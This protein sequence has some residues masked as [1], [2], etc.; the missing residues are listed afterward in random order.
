MNRRILMAAVSAALM[1]CSGDTGFAPPDPDLFVVQAYL[2]AGQP[3]T[4]VTITG[5]LP[6][7]AE[8]GEIA[9]PISDALVTLIKGDDRHE[10]TAT[11]GSP[12]AYHDPSGSVV[13]TP[14][15]AFELE[16]VVEGR[17]ARASTIVPQPPGGLV[18]S[19]DSLVAI[20][21]GVGGR[22]AFQLNLLRLDWDNP[23][24]VLHFVAVEGLDPLAALLPT[25]VEGGLAGGRFVTEPTPADSA[26]VS[27]LS[28]T[29]FGPHRVSLYRV[30]QEYAD[31]Y[32]G[33]VQD[34]RDL[35]EPPSNVDGALGIFTAFASDSAFFVVR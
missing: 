29:Y 5:V 7:D 11:S 18:L 3:V 25:A 24:S 10:L 14:G 27:Q 34:S 26:F 35:N 32:E 20:E 33:L 2:F 23:A 28:L 21:P 15:D 31:L 9:S 6:I 1:A 12:G 16:V 8:E 19:S 22:Q 4:D 30:N 13:V 17:T